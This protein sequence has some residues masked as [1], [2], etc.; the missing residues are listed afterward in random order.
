MAPGGGWA[1]RGGAAARRGGAAARRPGLKDSIGERSNNSNFDIKIRSK[2]CRN[3]K[4]NLLESIGNSA[5][6]GLLIIFWNIDS[7]KFREILIKIGA[8]FDEKRGEIIIFCKNLGK[9]PKTFH[10]IFL[11]F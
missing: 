5:F 4:K 6:W 7:A 10:E 8:K 2:F 1:T 9:N 11:K 3:S